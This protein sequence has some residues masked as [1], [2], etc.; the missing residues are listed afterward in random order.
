MKEN[1]LVMISISS[2]NKDKLKDI[3]NKISK[4]FVKHIILYH[5]RNYIQ[6]E[7]FTASIDVDSD[8]YITPS[9]VSVEEKAAIKD[10]VIDSIETALAG[11]DFFTLSRDGYNLR[12]D[13]L[14]LGGSFMLQIGFEKPK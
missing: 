10:I 11:V 1:L 14:L 3:S 12:L 5:I 8:V 4:T 7:K 9:L 2:S 6:K 13:G